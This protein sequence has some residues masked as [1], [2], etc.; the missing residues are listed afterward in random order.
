MS[1]SEQAAPRGS[2]E[3]AFYDP[4][5]ASASYVGAATVLAGFCF[6]AVVLTATLQ[7]DLPGAFDRAVGALLTAFLGLVLAGFLEVIVA[8]QTSAG[9]RTFWLAL[10]AGIVLSTSALFA[11]WGVSEII[12]VVFS[13][14]AA[15]VRGEHLV[16]L[17]SRVFAAGSVAIAALVA[18]SGVNLRRHAGVAPGRAWTVIVLWQLAGVAFAESLMR[19]GLTVTHQ[20]SI[21]RIASFQLV[22]MLVLVVTPLLLA[23]QASTR[24]DD[25]PALVRATVLAYGL[26]ALPTALAWALMARLA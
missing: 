3:P 16:D 18:H 22:G 1:T 11:L 21:A 17:V 23:S 25:G 14:Q 20:T 7:R 8:G 5:K 2:D 12:G 26:C 13:R 9:V 19:L 24:A 4:V 6:T 10:L 15:G